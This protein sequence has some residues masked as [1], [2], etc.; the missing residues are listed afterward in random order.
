MNIMMYDDHTMMISD[1][2]N[3]Y[4]CVPQIYEPISKMLIDDLEVL[5]KMKIDQNEDDKEPTE[6]F[7]EKFYKHIPIKV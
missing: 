6:C 7:N 1:N 3:D 5:R 2:T 4:I